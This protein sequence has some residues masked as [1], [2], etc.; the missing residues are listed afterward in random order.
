MMTI[1]WAL[2]A[3]L[4]LAITLILTRF[5]LR[6]SSAALRHLLLMTAFV[7][8]LLVPVAGWLLPRLEPV[9]RIQSTIVMVVGPDESPARDYGRAATDWSAVL[10]WLWSAG[11]LVLIARM[12]FA[13]EFRRRQSEPAAPAITAAGEALSRKLGLRRR[14]RFERS[15]AAVVAETR[16]TLRPVVTMPPQAELWPPERLRVV[17]MH[18]LLHIARH[19]WF[20]TVIA[21]LATALHWFN[22]LAWLALR[23]LR[24][25]RE[26]A[27]DDAVLLLGIDN[28]DYAGHL[29][30]IVS[31]L[32]SGPCAASVAMAQASH[33]ETRIRSILEPDSPRGGVTMKTQFAAA[34]F[35]TCLLLTA[36]AV[37]L[38]A[39]S[40]T[41]GL[42]GTVM[43]AS[44]GRVPNASVIVRNAESGK[45]E[46]LRT[47]ETGEFA[48]AALPAGTY[49]VE[50]ARAG[51]Q[52]FK[53]ENVVLAPGSAQ[54][55]SV[56]LNLGRLNETIT[57]TGPGAAPRP[58]PADSNR[59]P[60]RLRIGGNVQSAKVV[61]QVRPPYPEQAK[62]AGIE[63]TV[64]MEAVIG[65][66]GTL[67]NLQVLN[68]LVHPDLM[69]AA[70]EAVRQWQWEP[71]YLN[72]EPVEVITMITINFTLAK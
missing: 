71:T 19:D 6:R 23:D 20:A 69:Q 14:V 28:C 11:A 48:F 43:D 33:L 16:G 4:L 39:Q 47:N 13:L 53:K 9:K 66:D 41:A 30:E 44:S 42:S 3:S 22:P 1:S 35:A 26:I 38:P 62:A 70:T 24:R 37:L 59:P 67:Q 12:G 60:V 17:L 7:V 5:G 64:L 49:N 29:L 55:V 8:V 61:R 27:C 25:E 50:V 56:T 18:E 31:G 34:A 63:G 57:V 32:R 72:G 36:S 54:H 46:I 65:R 52:L 21:E 40:G 10:G 45:A 2:A 58:T 51:F 68:S 15:P